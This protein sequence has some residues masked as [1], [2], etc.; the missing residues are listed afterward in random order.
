MKLTEVNVLPLTV[1]FTAKIRSF[2]CNCIR[3][4]RAGVIEGRRGW[5]GVE[6][7]G[8]RVRVTGVAR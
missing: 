1:I 7:S 3:S 8:F 2:A 5:K 6:G 4:T